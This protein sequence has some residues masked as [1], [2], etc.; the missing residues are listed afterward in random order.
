MRQPLEL[1]SKYEQELLTSLSLR[2]WWISSTYSATDISSEVMGSSSGRD[3][4]DESKLDPAIDMQ[5]RLCKLY[6][7]SASFLQRN[8]N[9]PDVKSLTA[10]KTWISEGWR[11][12]AIWFLVGLAA[13]P[14]SGCST[15]APKAEED[16]W[17]TASFSWAGSADPCLAG[18]PLRG[19]GQN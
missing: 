16:R 4:I 7:E 8:Q 5:L 14:T 18:M 9:L 2:C 19:T 6:T 10:D 3:C 12:T 1:N 15:Q 13:C 17:D 11:E